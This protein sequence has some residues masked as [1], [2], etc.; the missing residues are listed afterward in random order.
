MTRSSLCWEQQDLECGSHYGALCKSRID[1]SHGV[2]SERL[3]LSV[4]VS[5]SFS[6]NSR[7]SIAIVDLAKNVD[8][9]TA[10]ALVGPATVYA[11]ATSLLHSNG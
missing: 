7:A 5:L 9:V 10:T 3:Y 2:I 8:K 6:L 1:L 11:P 4:S